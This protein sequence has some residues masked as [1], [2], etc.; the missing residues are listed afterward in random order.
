LRELAETEARLRALLA[1]RDAYYWL[2]QCTRTRDEQD[3]GSPYKTFP[4]LPY[5][6]PML[7]LL[8]REPVL[9]IEKSRTMMASWIVAGWASHLA[10]TH[11][12]TCVVFQSEDEDRAVHDIEYCKVL[13]DQSP[14][15][16]KDMWPLA[17]ELGKQPYNEF[18][19]AS[20]SKLIGI[21][22][23]PD[24]IR[25]EHPTA[26]I[27]DE[28]AHITEGEHSYNVAA[29]TRCP[30][31]IALSSAAPGWFRDYTEFA[32]PCDWPDYAMPEYAPCEM[33]EE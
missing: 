33:T 31:L 23:D 24:K 30:H 5:L 29:A 32:A 6:W 22:G 15:N 14:Q 18:R 10:F 25:S 4:E 13:W 16:L 19:L 7:R 3:P 1:S 9:F 2:T 27:L 17:K 21:P 8:D 11:P 12:A 26:V 20:A 28:A